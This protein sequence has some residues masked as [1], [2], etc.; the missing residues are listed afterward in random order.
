[1]IR[2]ITDVYVDQLLMAPLRNTRH[3]AFVQYL[4][5]SETATDAHEKAGYARDDGN[6]TR[7]AK[8]PKVMERLAELQAEI[9]GENKVTEQAKITELM[10]ST[11][12][13]LTKKI[14]DSVR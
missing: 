3:E 11:G 9:A 4:L 13:I 5:H 12:V 6:A 10:C 1:M 8:N 14:Y 2:S 7:L